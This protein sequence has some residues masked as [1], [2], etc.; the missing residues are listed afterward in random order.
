M[1]FADIKDIT[2]YSI[3]AFTFRQWHDKV[4]LEKAHKSYI[5]KYTYMTE[6]ENNKKK[7]DLSFFENSTALIDF[8]I[9][10]V[11]PLNFKIVK[12]ADHCIKLLKEMNDYEL[13]NNLKNN[14]LYDDYQNKIKKVLNFKEPNQ[15]IDLILIIGIKYL[16][17]KLNLKHDFGIKNLLNSRLKR[18]VIQYYM[19]LKH[20]NNILKKFTLVEP[21]CKYLDM[22]NIKPGLC[23]LMTKRYKYIM[24]HLFADVIVTKVQAFYRSYLCRKKYLYEHNVSEN[25]F[26]KNLKF[27]YHIKVVNNLINKK[28]KNKCA[29]KIQILWNNYIVRKYKL[30]VDLDKININNNNKLNSYQVKFETKFLAEDLLEADF[31]TNDTLQLQL[32]NYFYGNKHKGRDGVALLDLILWFCILKE[33]IDKKHNKKIYNQ[34]KKKACNY[35]LYTER[36]YK[37]H[38]NILILPNSDEIPNMDEYTYISEM[39]RFNIQRRYERIYAYELTF[40]TEYNACK[41]N[42]ENFKKKKQNELVIT[43]INSKSSVKQRLKNKLLIK[44]KISKDNGKNTVSHKDIEKAEI[45]KNELFNLIDR[46]VRKKN[47]IKSKRKSKKKKKKEKRRNQMALRI[48]SL[49]RMYVNKRNFKKKKLSIVKVQSYFRML[50]YYIKFKY[51]KNKLLKSVKVIKNFFKNF[52]FKRNKNK[53]NNKIKKKFKYFILKLNLKIFKKKVSIIQKFI[54]KSIIKLSYLKNKSIVKIQSSIRMYMVRKDFIL[55]KSIIKQNNEL[56]KKKK[57]LLKKEKELK[58]KFNINNILNEK[59]ENISMNDSIDTISFDDYD[60]NTDELCQKAFNEG[61]NQGYNQGFYNG[62]N[63]G[64]HDGYHKSYC[65]NNLV[66]VVAYPVHQY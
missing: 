16:I 49:F 11:S 20:N 61:Y 18:L 26:N 24:L 12:M 7:Y 58:E 1:S 54:K 15:G 45:C 2:K 62:C 33:G 29:K 9:Y 53:K 39:K 23:V 21:F 52:I 43:G 66:P 59:V 22:L 27:N 48:Q 41:N 35:Y 56:I 60:E 17:N 34:K 64:F 37:F 63:Q 50:N 6:Y 5:N 8:S 32:L 31:K 13:I 3:K 47:K 38:G 10:V 4:E 14:K 30:K 44:N 25:I 36:L 55:Y 46:D 40:K 57:E 51:K 28:F 65:D 19:R 42:F